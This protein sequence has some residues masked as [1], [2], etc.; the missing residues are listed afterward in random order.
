MKREKVQRSCKVLIVG[1]GPAGLSAAI[2]TARAG[3]APVVIT[4][5]QLG[6]QASLTADIENYPGFEETISG[7]DL[8]AKFQA[9]AEKFGAV[10]EYESVLRMDLS[11]A[12]FEVETDENIF[13]AEKIILATGSRH[14]LLNVPGEKELTGH[15]VSYCATCDGFLYRGK[16]VAVIGGGNSAVEEA[17]FL[18]RFAS[19]VTII[20]RRDSLRADKVVQEKAFTNPKISFIWDS[21]VVAVEGDEKV[22]GLRLKNVKTDEESVFDTDG[23][24][25]FVGTQTV[26]DLFEGQLEMEGNVVKVGPDMQTSVPGVYAAGETVDNRYRQVIVSAG[27][28]AQ[29]GISVTKAF[30]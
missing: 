26:T 7:M 9:Q 12:P 6:G 5:M 28:G 4:G 22:T 30:L 3:L 21:V 23:V 14:L 17:V 19:S 24:F 13:H 20:H 18:T 1:S 16:N 10:L 25:I 11:A 29:A 2:Y 27:S 8:L 15:G